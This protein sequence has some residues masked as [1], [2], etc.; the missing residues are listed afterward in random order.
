MTWLP[1]PKLLKG[2][3]SYPNKESSKQN[4]VSSKSRA[5]CAQ[6]T[7]RREGSTPSFTPE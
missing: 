7:G 5:N 2:R 3:N 6:G 4:G 1:L